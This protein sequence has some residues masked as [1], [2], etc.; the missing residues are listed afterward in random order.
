M[1]TRPDSNVRPAR[2]LAA[3]SARATGRYAL[4]RLLLGI[5]AKLLLLAAVTSSM[6]A[7]IIPVGPQW[8]DPDGIPNAPPEIVSET[9][10]AGTMLTRTASTGAT[11]VIVATDVN[12]TDILHNRWIVDGVKREAGMPP[13]VTADSRDPVTRTIFCGDVDPTVSL[14][15]VRVIV[16]DRDFATNPG[17]DFRAVNSP[18]K[19]D[20]RDWWLTMDCQP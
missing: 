3:Q 16:A 9:P 8:Q 15:P 10:A 19:T 13:M 6:P 11:F 1:R 2:R 4:A 20:V 17:P 12:V 14:H 5:S 7:C 18:G